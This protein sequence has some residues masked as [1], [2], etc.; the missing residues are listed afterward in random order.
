MDAD[1]FNETESKARAA[2]IPELH[3]FKQFSDHIKAGRERQFAALIKE[4]EKR[5][6]DE[7]VDK[8][9]EASPAH[10]PKQA[11]APAAGRRAPVGDE[12]KKEGAAAAA[13]KRIRRRPMQPD[14]LYGTSLTLEQRR[15]ILLA[16]CTNE[17][18]VTTQLLLEQICKEENAQQLSRFKQYGANKRQR[19]RVNKY[20]QPRN[21]HG[22]FTTFKEDEEG[23]Q[24][25]FDCYEEVD[26]DD[27]DDDGQIAFDYLEFDENDSDRARQPGKAR[28]SGATGKTLKLVPQKAG[29]AAHVA[30]AHPVQVIKIKKRAYPEKKTLKLEPTSKGKVEKKSDKVSIPAKVVRKPTQV[31]TIRSSD[32]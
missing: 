1:K 17:E 16:N 12:E 23:G 8:T 19:R 28:P 20:G 18:D 29:A 4:A 7:I 30:A 13:G 6:H 15:R 9:P 3:N 27:S 11:P 5:G 10:V 22:Q 26:A 2:Q 21:H 25:G 24:E 32:G 31:V 14:E